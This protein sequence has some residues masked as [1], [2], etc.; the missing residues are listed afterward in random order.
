MAAPGLS[1]RI[2]DEHLALLGAGADGVDCAIGWL[3]SGAPGSEAVVQAVSG[4]MGV[5]GRDRLAPRRLGLE[6][7]SV[8]AGVVAAQGVLAALI[9]RARGLGVQGVETSVFQAALLFLR[10]HL[11]IAT[12]GGRFPLRPAEEKAG[13]PFPTADGHWVELEALGHDA[14]DGF[15]RR[16]GLAGSETPGAAWLPFVYRYLAGRCALPAALQEATA[17]HTLEELGRAAAESGVAL[18]RLRTYGELLAGTPW[19]A[20]PWTLSPGTGEGPSPAGA[21]RGSA[22]LAGLR[23]IEVTSRMQGPL[24]GLLLLMLGADVVKVEPPGGDFGRGSPPLAGSTGAAYLAYNRGKRVVEIDFKRPEGKEEL[25]GL[26]AGADVFLHNWLEG[27]AG[28]LGLD[29]GDLARRNPRLVYAH[30]SGWGKDGDGAIAGDY[31]VQAHAGCGEGLNPEDEP[32]FPSR[33]TLIDVMGGLLA[34]EGI[35][36]GLY[37]RERDGRGRRV[38]TSLLGGALTLQGHVLQGMAVGREDGRRQGRP[39][40]GI[41]D[42]PLATA[43]GFLI[44]EAAGERALKIVSGVCGLDAG[45][46]LERRIAERLRARPAAEWEPE[47]NAAGIPAAAV[48]SDLATLPEDPRAAGLLEHADGACWLP[49]APWRFT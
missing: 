41:L 18:R 46:C 8:A 25:A 42:R 14:W 12:C 7:A 38:D 11:A 32:P 31:L 17:R 19:R 28:R 2:R 4:L 34:C 36:A 15:W 5:H 26:A 48:R 24:A 44:L 1:L 23:V 35:L 21:H 37:L 47:F 27:R 16:L 20:A 9:A 33:L 43:E 22:P 45:G 13:P 40:W 3:A 10:H 6:V 49:G 29:H 39:L 30:A